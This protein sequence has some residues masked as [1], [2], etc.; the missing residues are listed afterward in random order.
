[1]KLRVEQ[2]EGS[3]KK[4]KIPGA[5]ITRHIIPVM[6]LTDTMTYDGQTLCGLERFDAEEIPVSSLMHFIQ[7]NWVNWGGVVFC[8]ECANHP[9]AQMELLKWTE[10]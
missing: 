9:R 5:G 1:M 3:D 8:E 4:L 6:S 7:C 10:L 2:L